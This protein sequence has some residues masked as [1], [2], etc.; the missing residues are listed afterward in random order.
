MTSSEAIVLMR[1]FAL[2]AEQAQAAGDR[3]GAIRH[4]RAAVA[5]S[6]DVIDELLAINER[7]ITLATVESTSWM[8]S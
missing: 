8:A 2:S 4:A 5:A 7:P 3:A 6:H 1:S